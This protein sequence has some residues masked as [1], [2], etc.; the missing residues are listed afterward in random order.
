MIFPTADDSPPLERLSSASPGETPAAGPAGDLPRSSSAGSAADPPCGPAG[1]LPWRPSGNPPRLLVQ[2]FEAMVAAADPVRLLPELLPQ[3]PRGRTVVI[4]AGKAAASMARTVEEHW[5]GELSGIAVTRYGHGVPCWRVDAV[6]AGH[7]LPDEACSGAAA[8]ILSLVNGLSADDLV[9]VLLSGGGS[10]LLTLPAPGLTLADVRE[11]NDRLLRSG[12]AI[13]EINR[14]RKHLSAITGGRLAA[15]A[16]PAEVM[17]F[18]I[19]DVPGDDPAVI[20]SGPTVADPS[21][22]ADALEIAD[23]YSIRLPSAVRRH[24]ED[25]TD[26]TPKP[27]DPRLERSRFVLLATPQSALTVAAAAARAAGL[28]PLVL[29]A[30][31]QGEA[32]MVAREHAALVRRLRAAA[33]TAAPPT[34]GPSIQGLPGDGNGGADPAEVPAAPLLI[35]SGGE[36]T[37]TVTGDGRGGRNTEYLLALALALEA[38]GQSAVFAL[39]ADTD[40]ID[41]TEDNAGAIL[42][43]D[44]IARAR[45]AGLDPQAFLA[46][47]DGYGFFAALG[48][49][50]LTGPTRTNVNDFRA[51]LAL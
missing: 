32:R 43:P 49:L 40:G 33:P 5:P 36:T 14:V 51:I 19:S 18:A 28:E 25:A 17:T 15:A 2:L 10:S 9:L 37:V 39:A 27:G 46:A 48:D 21:T 22:F 24:L 6:E 12:A 38:E 47:N 30:D 11:V 13:G 23:R 50:V 3:P 4:G 1:N 16:W 8:R 20:A 35:L 42:R 45:A 26:E 44:T 34:A 41:G 7:P 31:V 29:G